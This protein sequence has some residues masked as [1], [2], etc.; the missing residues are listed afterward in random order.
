MT[1]TWT[2]QP[3]AGSMPL[4][5]IERRFGHCAFPF[6]GEDGETLSCCLP[7]AGEGSYCSGHARLC[8]A[9][10]PSG[11]RRSPRAAGASQTK[12]GAQRSHIQTLGPAK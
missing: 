11:E 4:P 1:L 6:D 5:W 7:V 8:Y 3:L 10:R 2:H 9:Q 12:E